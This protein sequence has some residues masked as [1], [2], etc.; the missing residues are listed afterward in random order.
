MDFRLSES[1]REKRLK[2]SGWRMLD[3]YTNVRTKSR[4][5]CIKCGDI[6]T[7]SFS[8]VTTRHKK[9]QCQNIQ[10]FG[11]RKYL[12]W[13]TEAKKRNGTLVTPHFIGNGKT[14]YLWM[15]EFGHQWESTPASVIGNRS[16]CPI[17]SGQKPRT[18]EELQEISTKRGG[19]V[20]STE[21]KGTEDFKYKFECS[22]G[23][24]FEN[25]FRHVVD[26]GQWCPICSKGTKSEELVR[27]SL[28]QIFQVDFNKNR[29]MWLRNSRNRQMEL[30][31]YNDELKLGF[32]YQGIQH[33]EDKSFFSGNQSSSLLDKQKILRQRIEDDQRKVELCKEH[34]V[35]LF[36][37]TCKCDPSSF[38]SEIKKQSVELGIDVELYNFNEPI[39]FS[40]SYIRDD[41]LEDLRK[42]LSEKHIQL[43]SNKWISTDTKYECLC[44]VCGHH[45]F[46]KG[47]SF[48]NRRRVSGCKKC[49]M[50]ELTSKQKLDINVLQEY[51]DKFGGKVLSREYVRRNHVYEFECKEGHVFKSNFNNMVYRNQFCSICEGRKKIIKS[52]GFLIIP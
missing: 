2:S 12:E 9:C 37:L 20:L 43:L 40:K 36:I 50:R 22:R 6:F 52:T 27:T 10:E 14:R 35:G 25:R 7:S 38:L 42:T 11:Q 41:R 1:E 21:Y 30:D 15:C 17:C 32:E 49:S 29:P 5:Q 39:D 33:F 3:E 18:F 24:V 31:G 23:H 16:W 28:Q 45:W 48:F 46:S 26:R 34:G 4:F 8:K 44:E 47:N 51:A 19:R 13:F